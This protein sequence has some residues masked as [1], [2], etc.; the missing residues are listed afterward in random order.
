MP[1]YVLDS[2]FFIQSHRF[3]NPLDI[4]LS[5]WSKI[6]KLAHSGPIISIDKVREEIY[7]SE[8]ELTEWCKNHLP[9]DFFKDSVS[10]VDEYA[11]VASWAATHEQYNSGAKEDFLSVNNAD[12]FLVTYGLGDPSNRVIVTQEKSA[13][14]SK[15]RILLPDACN[16]FGIRNINMLAL[17]RELGITF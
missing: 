9:D 12:A 7:S 10:L 3:S 1:E 2:N 5:F 15:K 8:D 6:E 14:D 4:S 13:P 16:H 17:F 11:Q